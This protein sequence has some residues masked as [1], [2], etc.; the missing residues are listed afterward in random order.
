MRIVLDLPFSEY[1]KDPSL[2]SHQAMEYLKSPLRY[3][4]NKQNPKEATNAMIVGRAVHTIILEPHKF[5]EEFVEMPSFSRSRGK[6]RVP[7]AMR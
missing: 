6:S 5:D 4:H 3:L 7:G 1:L 2:S